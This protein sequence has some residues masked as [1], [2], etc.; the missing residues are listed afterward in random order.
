M[1]TLEG[2][3]DRASEKFRLTRTSIENVQR[4]LGMRTCEEAVALFTGERE[5]ESWEECPLG[6]KEAALAYMMY[7]VEP[8]DPCPICGEIP[9]FSNPFMSLN[10]HPD[11]PVKGVDGQ[12]Y[13]KCPR[14]GDEFLELQG[15]NPVR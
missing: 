8:C 2:E 4:C 1:I 14:C 12:E 3:D 13:R 7:G 6:H 9:T 5:A 15:D 10:F 11:E